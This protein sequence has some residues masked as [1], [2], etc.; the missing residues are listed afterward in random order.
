MDAPT[1]HPMT[2]HPRRAGGWVIVIWREFWKSRPMQWS[3]G[4]TIE[5]RPFFADMWGNVT[6]DDEAGDKFLGWIPFP[7]ADGMPEHRP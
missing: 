6:Y 1:M 3:A 5:Q 2:D 4:D 7:D